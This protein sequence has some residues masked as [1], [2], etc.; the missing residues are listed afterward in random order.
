M[1]Q[2]RGLHIG[3]LRAQVALKKAQDALDGKCIELME[4][5]VPEAKEIYRNHGKM[6]R[7][8]KQETPGV[9]VNTEPRARREYYI[10]KGGSGGLRGKLWF[11]RMK[12]DH[13]RELLKAAQDE[14]K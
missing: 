10:N 12:A 9:I 6:K 4:P 1:I 8:H 2:F 5:Y 13:M 7:A 11:E 3:A 14:L